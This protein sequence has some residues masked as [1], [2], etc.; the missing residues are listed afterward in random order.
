MWGEV[1]QALVRLCS[2]YRMADDIMELANELV[3]EGHMRSASVDVAQRCLILPNPLPD[4][5]YWLQE[6]HTSTLARL[7]SCLLAVLLHTLSQCPP[8]CPCSRSSMCVCVCV[9]G[10]IDLLLPKVG[11]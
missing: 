3:Y 7:P 11:D 9:F 8:L 10:G 6:V 1:G 5:P 2:Q 4:L